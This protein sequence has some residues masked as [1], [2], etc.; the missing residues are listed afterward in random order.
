MATPQA[1]P[2]ADTAGLQGRRI[3]VCRPEPEGARLATALRA[4]GAQVHLLPAVTRSPLPETPE[5][6]ALLQQLDNFRHVIAVSPYAARLLLDEI[7]HWWPQLPAGIRWY[8]VGSGTA[9]VFAEA[10][11]QGEK[12]DQGWTS[13][14]LLAHPDLQQIRHDKVLIARGEQGRELTR[15]TLEHRGARVTVLPLYR[16]AQPDYPAAKL[17]EVFRDFQPEAIIALSGETLTNLRNLAG[18]Y[19]PVTAHAL[20]VVPTERVADQAR[21]L[22]FNRP[23]I[24]DGLSD[25]EL[26]RSL[27]RWLQPP[28]GDNG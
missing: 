27:A 1:E 9:A 25:P 16:R 3:L 15:Q 14:A 26:V 18:E 20:V 6:R 21:A 13:E 12:P 24:P 11:V 2:C 10:G 4:A 28:A 19:L 8:G 23:V 17:E 5:R 22:G 7:D